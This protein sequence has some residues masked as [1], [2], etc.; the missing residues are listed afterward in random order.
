MSWWAIIGIAYG[1]LVLVEISW[2]G[3]QA[4]KYERDLR[5]HPD[6]DMPHLWGQR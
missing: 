6:P 1:L 3:W 4:W 5:V 2:L